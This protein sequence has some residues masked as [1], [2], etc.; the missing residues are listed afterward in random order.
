MILGSDGLSELNI[1]D[2]SVK[3]FC[4]NLSTFIFLQKAK[5]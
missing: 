1:V 5:D 4:D 3:L 2:L